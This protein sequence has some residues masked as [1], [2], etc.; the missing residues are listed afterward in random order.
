MTEEE[1]KRLGESCAADEVDG[2][3][4]AGSSRVLELVERA[5]KLPLEDQKWLIEQLLGSIRG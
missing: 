2:A 1:L 5:R 3:P 4:Q